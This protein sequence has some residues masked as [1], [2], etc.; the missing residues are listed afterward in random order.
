[1]DGA[2]AG[3]V[4]KGAGEAAGAGAAEPGD[5][6][7]GAGGTTACASPAMAGRGLL[8]T[9]GAG[10]AC[11]GLAAEGHAAAGA[12]TGTGAAGATSDDAGTAT[13]RV[14]S[15]TSVAVM[16]GKAASTFAGAGL[17]HTNQAS[18]AWISNTPAAR[19]ARWAVLRSAGTSGRPDSARGDSTWFMDTRQE[20]AERT[21]LSMYG[22]P[23]LGGPQHRCEALASWDDPRS[24]A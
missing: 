5:T 8:R 15:V 19:P 9:A 1:M 12:G 23:Q 10:A 22:H 7:C 21:I 24:C 2:G 11:G 13:S 4:V 18:T 14:A 6:S 17:C 16:T 20:S 3:G